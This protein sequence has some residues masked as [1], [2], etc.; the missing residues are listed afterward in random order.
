MKSSKKYQPT[1]NFHHT[2]WPFRTGL[3][4]NK[5]YLLQ[6]EG[7]KNAGSVP[8]D[9]HLLMLIGK[10]LCTSRLARLMVAAKDLP[11]Q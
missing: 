1:G 6:K 8:Q 4:N 7:N 11:W 5:Q 3:F 10:S 9:P 2:V